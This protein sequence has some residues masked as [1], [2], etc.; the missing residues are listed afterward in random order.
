MVAPLTLRP[1]E[2][3]DLP[4]L[5]EL[6]GDSLRSGE[7]GD[8]LGDLEV[9][10]ERCERDDRVRLVVA[11]HDG[12]FAGAVLLVVS[13]VSP[14]NLAPM[15]HVVSPT[16][17]E[18]MRRRGVGRSL[19]EAGVAYAEELE[20]AQIGTASASTSRDANR[21]M[22]R[23]GLA[24]RASFRLAPTAAVRARINAMRPT[25]TRPPRQQLGHVLAA[26]RSMRRQAASRAS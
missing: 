16:V 18:G 1:A 4:S 26:R 20:I 13:T 21:F 8:G 7:A 9:V 23:L 25:M 11:E 17:V 6:W 15:V 19:V 2:S 5:V 24:T 3:S 12:T 10:L 22:A 14:L